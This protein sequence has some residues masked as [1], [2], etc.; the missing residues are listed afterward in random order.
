[1]NQLIEK[2]IE[3]L[4]SEY[5]VNSNEDLERLTL[6]LRGVKGLQGKVKE[7]LDPQVLQAHK[8]H[9]GLTELRAKY[10][11]PLQAIEQN[12]NTAIKMWHVKQDAEARLIND[13]I[14]KELAEEAEKTKQEELKKAMEADSEWEQE[15]AL[16]K[17]HAI[18]P[19][20][21]KLE[22]VKSSLL[23][24]QEGQYKRDNWKAKIVDETLIPREYLVVN[25]P[26]LNQL[27]KESKGQLSVQGVEC[28]NDFT[29]VTRQ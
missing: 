4:P 20:E 7:E 17:A 23:P 19:V 5:E 28:W 11:N 24:K 12:I 9:K 16:A 27:A 22:D 10:L 26:L 21:V 14:N 15:T 29:I 25:M 6:V 13:R 8:A 3:Q 18:V 2:E 1:M